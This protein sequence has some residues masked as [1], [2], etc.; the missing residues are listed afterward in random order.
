MVRVFQRSVSSSASR[1]DSIGR[2]AVAT[3]MSGIVF[4][5]S[6]V[7]SR[8][9]AR[10]S[11]CLTPF[12]MPFQEYFWNEKESHSAPSTLLSP[13]AS[14]RSLA[15]ASSFAGR[16]FSRI[17]IRLLHWRNGVPGAEA[18]LGSV[19]VTS[20][21]PEVISGSPSRFHCRSHSARAP[22]RLARRIWNGSSS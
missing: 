5:R 2:N 19:A 16:S 20:M 21:S 3:G 9:S 7:T 1:L 14:A 8:P 17:W 18:V 15:S 13:A 4:F 12:P 11:L 6:S 10:Y 22:E